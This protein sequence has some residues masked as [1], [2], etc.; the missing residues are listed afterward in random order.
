M[1]DHEPLRE[2]A[3]EHRVGN[4]LHAFGLDERCPFNPQF[5]R[6]HVRGRA[7]EDETPNARWVMR[8]EPHSDHSAE[9]EPD[10]IRALDPQG[11]HESEH[12]AGQVGDLIGAVR[13]GR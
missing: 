11:I 3:R 12:I 7:G 2:P 4:R 10:E 6:W 5:G 8:P 9:R 1:L 13:G